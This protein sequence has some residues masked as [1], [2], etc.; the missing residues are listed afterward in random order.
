[1][2]KASP[3]RALRKRRMPARSGDCTSVLNRVSRSCSARGG[4]PLVARRAAKV[5]S[6]TGISIYRLAPRPGLPLSY[7]ATGPSRYAL[8]LL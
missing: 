6:S 4:A 2:S 8:V 5:R 7:Q 1:M 3:A